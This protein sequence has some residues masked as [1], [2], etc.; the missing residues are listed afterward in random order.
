MSSDR[1]HRCSIQDLL[2]LLIEVQQNLDRELNLESLARRY[3]HSPSHFHR[4]F[5]SLVG[6]TPKKYVE[7]LRLEKAAYKLQI[8]DESLL[9]IALSVGFKNHETFTRAFN[10]FFGDSPNR[11]R[12]ASKV[13]QL[14]RLERNRSFSGGDCRLSEV[15]FES[16]R[17]MRLLCI[18]HLGDYYEIPSALTDEDYLWNSLI[19]WAQNNNI[20]HTPI[21]IGI[22]YDDP[23]MTPRPSQRCDACI[24]ITGTVVGNQ[25]IRC[26]EFAGGK[27]GVIEHVGSYSTLDQAFR[28]LADGIRASQDY[29]FRDDPPVVV[30]RR[31]QVH[32][33]A[34]LNHTD[35][36]FPVRKKG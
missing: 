32:G 2:P 20:T 16:L 8:T 25:R 13:A 11:L 15:R 12:Q 17:S 33:D 19:E 6:E 34:S 27:H 31:I 18:R 28:K 36:Y 23:T 9:S 3:G 14:E 5:S 22:Y 4:L 21:P 29:V 35:V 7:R 26:I 24:P 1:L 30:R 10:R